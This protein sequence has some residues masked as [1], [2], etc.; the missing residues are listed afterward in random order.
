[1]FSRARVWLAFR[2]V[3]TVSR[4]LVIDPVLSFS[5]YLGGQG[6]DRGYGIALDPAGNVYITGETRSANFPIMNALQSSYGGDRNDAFVTK[7][8]PSGTAILYS[9]Y[10]GGSGGETGYDIAVDSTGNAYVTGTTYSTNFPTT[11]G[12]LQRT[13]ASG[14]E[15]F[16]SKLNAEGNALVYSTFLGGS[17]GDDASGIALDSSGNAYVTGGTDSANFPTAGAFQR[18]KGAGQ[19]EDV[20]VTKINSQG[21]ALVFSTYLGSSEPEGGFGIAIDSNGSAYVTGITISP[22]FPTTPGAFQA[23]Y[24]GEG[25]AFVTKLNPQGSALAYSTFLGGRSVDHGFRIAVDSSGNAFLTGVTVSTNFPTANPLQP[26]SA[27]RDDAF[28]TKL[29]SSGTAL[30]YSTY[31]GGADEDAG[32][33]IAIDVL[34]NAY[35]TGT[36]TSMNFPLSAP[37]QATRQGNRDAF[38]TKLSPSGSEFPRHRRHTLT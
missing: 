8:N 9:T 23:S 5:S 15:G 31:F 6:G 34:G 37:L 19:S 4:P 2:S 27:G 18:T 12:A 11:P 25:D 30:R 28:V 29:N 36:T 16:V 13:I 7:L 20:F 32:F 14:D 10:L 24:A 22:G 17:G 3:P 21:S 1:M 35:V 38:F 33:D 26:T